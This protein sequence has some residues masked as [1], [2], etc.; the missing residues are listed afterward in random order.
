MLSLAVI[1]IVTFFILGMD[2]WSA[3][4]IVGTI[5]CILVNLIGLMYWWNIDFNAISVVNLVMV[6]LFNSNL[7]SE[8]SVLVRWNFGGIL[9]PHCSGILPLIQTNSSRTNPRSVG[10]HWL[11]S[12]EWNHIHEIRGCHCSRLRTHP[13]FPSFL[14]SHV[15]WNC[16]HRRP[17]R[18]RLPSGAPFH[19]W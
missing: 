10:E 6:S 15:F 13:N 16:H 2:P 17:S 1:F 9:F 7:E 19:R 18:S 8:I 14:L 4:I 3:M 5:A 11:L 12:V